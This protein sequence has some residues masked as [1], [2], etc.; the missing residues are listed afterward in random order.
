MGTR[1]SSFSEDEGY[2]HCGES[3]GIEEYEG[4]Q[5]SPDCSDLPTSSFQSRPSQELRQGHR[6]GKKADLSLNE[7]NL[8]L[9]SP[10]RFGGG[11]GIIYWHLSL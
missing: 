4:Y 7:L 6:C 5:G 9:S 1:Y 3:M 11:H 10:G 8:S 2:G